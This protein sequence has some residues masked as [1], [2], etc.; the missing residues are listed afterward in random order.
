ME[1]NGSWRLF[2]PGVNGYWNNM[3][4]AALRWNE[5]AEHCAQAITLAPVSQ[6]APSQDSSND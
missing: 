4:P 3:N 2:K 5:S 6:D 1:V